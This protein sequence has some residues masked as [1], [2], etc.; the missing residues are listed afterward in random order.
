MT[1]YRKS[2]EVKSNWF[3]LGEAKYQD[4][5]KIGNHKPVYERM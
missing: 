4:V 1:S 3:S 2:L 5:V